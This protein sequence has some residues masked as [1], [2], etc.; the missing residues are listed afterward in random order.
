MVD[1]LTLDNILTKAGICFFTGVPDSCFKPWVDYLSET[2]PQ[3]YAVATNEGEALS[4]AAGYNLA[5][6][7]VAGVYLQNSGL[8]NLLNPI[9][10]VIDEYVYEIPVLL[11]ISWRGRPGASDEPQHKRMG[12]ITRSL[13]ELLNIKHEIFG[14]RDLGTVLQDMVNAHKSGRPYAIIFQ[15]GDIIAHSQSAEGSEKETVS[16]LTRWDA[17]ASIAQFFGKEAVYFATTGKTSRELYF[18][19]DQTDRDHSHD[20]LNVG[21]MG[22]VSSL[23]FGFSIR[24]KKRIVILD[25]DGSILMHMGNLATIG[26][27]KPSNVIHFILDNQSHESVGGS[28]TV[29]GTVDFS[30]LADSVGYRKSVKVSSE[31]E[32]RETL[33]KLENKQGPIL[34]QVTIKKGS[35]PNLPRPTMSPQERKALFLDGLRTH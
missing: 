35:K 6:G 11:M 17:I 3:D 20:F 34:V 26:H 19:R 2:R 13:L 28:A 25:G 1:C 24:S 14:Q 15:K 29:S 21:G 31:M 8:G 33:T 23:A 5:T 10:S 32:L 27:Y 7:K 12:Q 18:W 16:Q 9:S 4:I 22:W 30:R